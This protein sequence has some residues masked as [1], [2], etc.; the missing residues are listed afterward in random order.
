MLI[1]PCWVTLSDFFIVRAKAEANAISAGSVV[2]VDIARRVD[3]AE[4]G[5]I[6]SRRRPKP[7]KQH[8]GFTA[9]DLLVNKAFLVAFLDGGY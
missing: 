8:G 2:V 5:R 4:V 3:N 7:T 9:Y 1:S 6:V